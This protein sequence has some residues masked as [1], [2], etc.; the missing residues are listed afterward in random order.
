[1]F[2]DFPEIVSGW[3]ALRSLATASRN[4]AFGARKSVDKG[5]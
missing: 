4:A 2:I 1:M 5:T 3:I